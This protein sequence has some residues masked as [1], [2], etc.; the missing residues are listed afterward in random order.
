MPVLVP[1]GVGLKINETVQAAAASM[2]CPQ[3]VVSKVKHQAPFFFALT[4]AHLARCAAAILFRPAADMV[5]F[6]RVG[7]V[8]AYTPAKAE[9]AALKPESCFCTWSRSFF[10]CFISLLSVVI[11]GWFPLEIGIISGPK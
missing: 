3:S 4:L 7:L 11:C 6:L 1:L 8:P 9:I 10:N 5:R 2:V